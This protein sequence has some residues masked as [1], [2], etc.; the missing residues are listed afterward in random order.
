MLRKMGYLV[1]QSRLIQAA[2]LAGGW[3]LCDKAVRFLALP[4]P[5]GIVGLVILLALL[6]SGRLRTTW[7]R[8]GTLG[9]LDHMVLFFVPAVI[10][11]LNHP[12][13]L[14]VVGVKLLAVI[15]FSTLSVM[16][17]TAFAVERCFLWRQGDGQ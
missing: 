12:E 15:A 5:S 14:G 6:Q 9:L 10:A 7:V 2:L 8:R 1:R 13:L 17:G 11:L 4:V 3:W 16:V